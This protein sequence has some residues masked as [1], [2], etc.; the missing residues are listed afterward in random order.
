M[1]ED[2]DPRS[3]PQLLAALSAD[4]RALCS[5]TIGLARAE[6]H[7]TTSALVTATAG[8]VAGILVL[9]LGLAV[10]T[11]ALVLIAVAVGL[12]PWA[13]ALLVGLL[14]AA[15]GAITVWSFLAQLKSLDYN[16]TETRRSVTETLTWLK[17]QTLP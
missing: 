11:A 17:A 14:L 5:E 10:L 13:A 1:K 6:I 2:L 7:R 9:L 15:G 4:L 12:P 3:V 8:I 16:L